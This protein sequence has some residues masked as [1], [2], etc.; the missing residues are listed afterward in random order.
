MGSVDDSVT[1]VYC[2]NE[3]ILMLMNCRGDG[4]VKKIQNNVICC[5]I[6]M[7]WVWEIKGI[8]SIIQ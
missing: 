4:I 7:K 2:R 6:V 3:L 8:I 5:N 1:M